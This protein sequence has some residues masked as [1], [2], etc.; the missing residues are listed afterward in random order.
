MDSRTLGPSASGGLPGLVTS[1]GRLV[2][3][4]FLPFKRLRQL[5]VVFAQ[6]VHCEAARRLGPALSGEGSL[7]FSGRTMSMSPFGNGLLQ[8]LQTG[9]I[10]EMDREEGNGP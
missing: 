10:Q 8:S 5:G 9:G 2:H 3:P 4:R 7:H 6:G 1:G